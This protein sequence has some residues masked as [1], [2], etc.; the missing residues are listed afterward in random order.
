MDGSCDVDRSCSSGHH[1]PLLCS[2]KAGVTGWGFWILDVLLEEVE[3][4]TCSR[5]ERLIGGQTFQPKKTGAAPLLRP[6]HVP[7]MPLGLCRLLLGTGAVCFRHG[8]TPCPIQPPSSGNV[9]I[10]NLEAY[11]YCTE[12]TI[13]D[14]S[15]LLE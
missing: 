12:N 8:I 14:A 5:E 7:M 3:G 15:A 1:Y 2:P 6:A 9:F 10:C 4:E 13:S 11:L